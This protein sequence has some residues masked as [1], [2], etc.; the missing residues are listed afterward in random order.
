[1]K[2]IITLDEQEMIDILNGLEKLKD[3]ASNEKAEQRFQTY[4][5]RR[6]LTVIRG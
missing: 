4:L 1:M 2:Y 3:T 5:G 6:S